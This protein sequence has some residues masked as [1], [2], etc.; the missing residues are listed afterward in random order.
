MSPSSRRPAPKPPI[1]GPS[2]TRR[3]SWTR[4]ALRPAWSTTS[5]PSSSLRRIVGSGQLPDDAVAGPG[6]QPVGLQLGLGDA[7][8]DGAADLLDDGERDPGG[9][10]VVAVAQAVG[11]RLQPGP[12]PPPEPAAERPRPGQ[13]GRHRRRAAAGGELQLEVVNLARQAAILVDQLPVEQVQSRVH[14]AAGHR[15][16][17]PALVRII[18]GIVATATTTSNRR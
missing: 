16:Q 7:E 2:W 3:T 12:E 4:P 17:L 5:A 11:D 18:N 14:G 1:R 15:D 8:V 13:D 9:M 10:V 6:L